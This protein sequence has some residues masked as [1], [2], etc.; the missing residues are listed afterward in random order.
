M[1][2]TTFELKYCERCGAL[3]LRRPHSPASYC[4]PCARILFLLPTSLHRGRRRLSQGAHHRQKRQPAASAAN[5]TP[6][7]GSAVR[8]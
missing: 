7:L 6:S 1:E 8:P 5:A 3:G 4:E 2:G